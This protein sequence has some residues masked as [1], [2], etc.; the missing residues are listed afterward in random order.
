MQLF[1]RTRV[2]VEPEDQIGPTQTVLQN[3]SKVL[4]RKWSW[5]GYGLASVALLSWG[6]F[7]LPENSF[8]SWLWWPVTLGTLTI[9]GGWHWRQGRTT[10]PALA[11]DN[12]KR[13]SFWLHIPIGLLVLLVGLSLNLFIVVKYPQALRYDSYEYSRIAYEYAQKGYTPDA[14][15]SPGYTLPLAGIYKLIGGAQPEPDRV[16]GPPL[17]ASPNLKVMWLV[18][19]LMLSG[20]AFM[21]YGLLIEL[22]KP[23]EIV[24]WRFGKLYLGDPMALMGAGLVALCPFLIAYTSVTLTEIAAAFWLT[25]ATYLWVK[26]LKYPETIFYLFWLGLSLGWLMQTRPTFVYL[27]IPALLVLALFGKQWGRLWQPAIVAIGLGLVLWPQFAANLNTFEEAGPVLASDL[28]TY[29]TAVG[30]YYVT[31][32]GIP[33]YQTVISEASPNPTAE[34]IWERLSNYLPL[35]LGQSAEGTPLSKTD[36][37]RLTAIESDYFKQYFADYVRLKPME[38]QGTVGKR[39]WFMW[40]QHYVFP[41][42]DPGYFEYRWLTD[43][44]NRLYLIFGLLG[45]VAAGWRW[46]RGVWP[47]WTAIAYLMAVNAVVRIEFRYTLPAYPLLL[48]F[49]ALGLWE[50][51]RALRGRTSERVRFGTLAGLG[52]TV[53][54]VAVLS[55]T[56]P[57]IPPTTV[58][59]EKALDMLAQA[60]DLNNVRQFWAAEPIYNQAIASYPTEPQLWNGRANFYVGTGDLAKSLPDFAKSL[61]LDPQAADPYR[62]RGQVYQKL[63]RKA[64]A[65]ADFE[66]YL[67]LAPPKN[68]YRAKVERELQGL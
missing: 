12:L 36:R 41:Y 8:L 55:I 17:P 13:L 25:L 22:R 57:L 35:Q 24:R 11:K 26:A 28:S 39:L 29:Q 40:D 44:L 60:D 10:Q 23:S 63:G 6:F 32:G 9:I 16:F 50:V 1:Q 68:L 66:K 15:R 45:I 49:A 30:I 47:L 42:Y 53:I 38:F 59:R 65:K 33:R 46:G 52:I 20:I 2:T 27:P 64:E 43:N 61:E 21:V 5:A 58:A 48:A 31:Y 56:L 4:A 18:Q 37:K 62:W 7:I 14:I 3:D 67:Q 54:L 34:P 51:G 19:A